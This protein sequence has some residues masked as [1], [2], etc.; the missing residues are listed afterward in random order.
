GNEAN[1]VKV[2]GT[3]KDQGHEVELFKETSINLT[4][5]VDIGYG[6][7]VPL[8]KLVDLG[9]A[10][11]K[12][13]IND[14]VNRLNDADIEINLYGTTLPSGKRL[15]MTV[16]FDIKATVLYEKCIDTPNFF[17][18]EKCEEGEKDKED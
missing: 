13:K 16:H 7:R 11:L 18:G 8:Q 14:H 17:G 5:G 6:V 2:R 1:E 15:L 12:T 9:V 3:I 10:A 4:T